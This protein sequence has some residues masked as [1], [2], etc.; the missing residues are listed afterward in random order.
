ML[1][2]MKEC[3]EKDFEFVS[4][5]ALTANVVQW[6]FEVK[7]DA[8]QHHGD[9]KTERQNDCAERNRSTLPDTIIDRSSAKGI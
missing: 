2:D 4:L 3:E 5:A 7:H 8:C 6:L 9:Q 1:L